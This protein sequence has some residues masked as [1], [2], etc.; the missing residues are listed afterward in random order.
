MCGAVYGELLGGDVMTEYST[1]IECPHVLHSRLTSATLGIM[2]VGDTGMMHI[3][4]HRNGKRAVKASVHVGNEVD[5]LRVPKPTDGW[6]RAETDQ[7]C[8]M[9]PLSYE[10]TVPRWKAWFIVQWTLIK[11]WWRRVLRR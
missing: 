1:A 9:V 10:Y 4:E 2:I 11:A 5:Y 3:I 8:C 6:F 7:G